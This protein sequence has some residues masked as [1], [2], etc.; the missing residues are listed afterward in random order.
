MAT[1]DHDDKAVEKAEASGAGGGTAAADDPEGAD[2]ARTAAVRADAATAALH[3]DVRR[4]MMRL[5]RHGR[6]GGGNLQLPEAFW[7]SSAR[8]V[9]NELLS[10]PPV[11]G[12][13]VSTA[14]VR[15]LASMT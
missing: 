5:A 8:S 10:A 7:S 3:A 11:P 6:R 15:P 4:Q 12:S 14:R 2:P 9:E 1:M 13:A